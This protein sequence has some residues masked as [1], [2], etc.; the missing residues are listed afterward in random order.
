M[1]T[2]TFYWHD[3]ETWGAVPAHDHPCQFAGVR[4]DSNLNV[5]G[6]PLSIYCQP[7]ADI[8][9]HPQATLVTGIT[10]QKARQEG[11]IP[12][13][14]MA[15]IH[16]ELAKPGTCGVGYNSL[17]FDDEITRYSLYR[18]FYDPYARE[19]QNSCSRWDII[20]MV[21]LTYALRPEGIEWP[22]SQ[23]VGREHLPSFKL[24]DL[25]KANGILHEAAHDALSDVYATIGMARLIKE[26]Q[27]KLFDHVFSHRDKHSVAAM[28]NVS[29]RSPVL[30]VSGM[31]GAE[32]GYLGLMMPLAMHPTNKNSVICFN[33]SDDPQALL[34]LDGEA[35]RER[36]FSSREL[37]AEKGLERLAVKT[38]QVNKCPIVLPPKMLT[39]AVAERFAID[40]DACRK[41]WQ[42]L[43]RAD[44]QAKLQALFAGEEFAPNPD[45]E[46]ALY[47]GF[48]KE[49]DKAAINAV[50]QADEA[51]L[52]EQSFSFS[53]PRLATLLLR[54][55]ARNYPAS[56]SDE[57]LM[58]WQEYC[59]ERVSQGMYPGDL[60][61]E[62]YH[63][64][65][66]ELL[67]TANERDSALLHQLLAYGDELLCG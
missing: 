15:R 21:R 19:W 8:V 58:Q 42:M 45:P 40:L 51:A 6:E 37:L 18:N 35:L 61:L 50:R 36:V 60:G 52:T 13:E 63:Q 23:I 64:V 66:D 26:K 1:T 49:Q 44:V 17:R 56:L 38:I 10:P 3:Y 48:F 30:H 12:A 32:R 54:Y 59:F 65:I 46:Q 11:L 24:E 62:E 14:F 57:E 47:G 5:I 55:K 20:D 31:L 2:P 43:R 25:S 4:T 39:E 53:D 34:E 33:L 28:L 7:P 27:P 16:A 67:E 22:L 41:H 9:P 29:E